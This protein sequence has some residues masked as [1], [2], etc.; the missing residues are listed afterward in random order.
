MSA[1]PTPDPSLP[2]GLLTTW[3]EQSHDLLALVDRAGRLRW[4]NTA[5]R[6]ATGSADGAWFGVLAPADFEGGLAHAALA[7]AAADAPLPEAEFALRT[8]HGAALWVRARVAP[9][10]EERLWT[11]QDITATR[12]L[13]AQTQRLS[14]LLELAQEFGR[15]GVWEREIPS[16]KGRWDR[17]VFGFWGIEEN[18]A[19]PDHAY[20]KSRV[21]P[22]DQNDYYLESTRQAGRYAKHYRVLHADGSLRWIHSQWEVKNSPQGVP[23]RTIGIMMDDT[24]VHDLAR[25]RDAAAAELRLVT[26][27][28]DI[29]IWRHDFKTERIH[30]DD[31]AFQVLGI[32]YRPDGLGIDEAR[33]P[34]HPDDV[35][36]LAASSAHALAT[37]EPIDVEVRHRRA[38]GV[39]R[40]IMVRRVIER[41]PD[42]EPLG[43]VGI[44]LDVT[45]RH[46]ALAAPACGERTLGA[47]R[48]PCRHRHL[49][50]G[51][52]RRADLG[53]PD[54]G[55]ARPGATRAGRALDRQERLALV[56]PD[57][58]AR[59]IDASPDRIDAAGSSAY[60]F[61][62]RWPDGSYRWLASRSAPLIEPDGGST[63]RVGVNWDI[64][65]SKNADLARQQALL[66][67][68]ESQAKSRF[69]SRM[70]HELRTPLNAV[71]GFAQLLQLETRDVLDQRQRA[72][73]DHIR[74]AASTC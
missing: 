65:E 66:A 73:L 51:C 34:T 49:A 6:Q 26:R 37:G 57:D 60:E 46:Q 5:F 31:H 1:P 25:S 10:G 72:R 22:A 68:R 20:A 18:E 29:V 17:H 39:W 16:G 40:Y 61:R 12:A 4:A 30:Y 2:P 42:G 55:A 44:L 43:F 27:L 28:A 52:R 3:L 7:A 14:E 32:P 71:L 74:T 24:I 11:L 23:V 41:G 38:D 33:A 69:L 9:L 56:H 59:V 64:T 58:R 67:E 35:A 36:K 53:C 50:H 63:R 21:H 19:T 15:L 8:V 54:V 47:D 48:A 13:A 45:E 70:S 62:V